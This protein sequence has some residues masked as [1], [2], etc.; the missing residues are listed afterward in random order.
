[1]AWNLA[2]SRWRRRRTAAAFLRRQRE[3]YTEGPSP[4]RITLLTA[5]ATLPPDQR[6][7]FVLHYIADMSVADISAQESVAPG[8]VKS[9]LYRARVALAAR[10]TEERRSDRHG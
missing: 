6:R 2:R 3:E 10:L 9:W 1:M 5:L 7:V 4:D 8:T